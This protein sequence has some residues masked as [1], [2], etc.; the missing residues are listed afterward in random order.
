MKKLAGVLIILFFATYF[1]IYIS[2]LNIPTVIIYDESLPALANEGYVKY[3]ELLYNFISRSFVDDTGR[4]ITNLRAYEG[5]G[6]TLS[7]SI[8]L[9]MRYCVLAGKKKQFDR[10]V[11]FLTENML[12]KDRLVRWRV[13]KDGADCNAAIDDLRIIRA[14]TDAYEKWGTKEYW[15]LAGFL[16]E[17]LFEFQVNGRSLYEF[18][19]WKTEKNSR[20]IP[21]CYLDLYTMDCLSEFNKGWLGV[22]E[23]GLSILC[24]GRI[25]EAMPFYFKYYDYDSGGYNFDEE[26]KQGKGICLTYTL[27]TA[28]HLA[29][30]N[31]ESYAL[32]EW[33][34][35]EIKKGTLYAWYNP[36]T[37]KPAGSTESAAVYALAAAY[38]EKIGEKELYTQ[39][40]DAMLKFSV[41]DKKSRYYGGIGDPGS[42]Y[43]HSFDNL[44]ALWALGLAD[45]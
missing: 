41:Q 34:K 13:G 23:K 44:T 2:I 10:E 6:D 32:T 22:E 9:F 4:I 38:A 31:E 24:G 5:S 29:E 28:L 8:G 39:L 19:D 27:I 40:T 20:R 7:E 18:Y 21:L 15:D 25:N 12:A 3:E 33:L 37:L 43:F 26:Y 1:V 42:G 17:G 14:L 45:H 35:S 11:K 16:Q 30:V 36:H